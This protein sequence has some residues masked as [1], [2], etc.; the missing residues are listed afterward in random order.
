[1]KTEEELDDEAPQEPA[2]RRHLPV[3][4]EDDEPVHRNVRKREVKAVVFN[5]K[6]EDPRVR[7]EARKAC[8][9]VFEDYWRPKVRSDCEKVERPCCFV[10]C[11]WNLYLD[12]NE[13]TGSIRFNFPDLHPWEM[14]P[15][16]SCAKDV[17]RDEGGTTL[18]RVADLLNVTRERARQVEEIILY[19]LKRGWKQP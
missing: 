16:E 19:K 17:A 2:T 1:M 11:Q 15:N 4:D 18:A 6:R 3:V 5:P 8:T 12:V 9:E 14:A 7:H 10:G 13:A